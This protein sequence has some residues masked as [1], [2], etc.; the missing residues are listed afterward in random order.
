MDYYKNLNLESIDGE[1]WKDVEGYEGYYAISSLGRVRSY[2]RLV[3]CE[4]DQINKRRRER[5]LRQKV[6]RCGYLNI[7][8]FLNKIHKECPA[9]VLVAKAFIP[10]PKNKPQVNHKF[11]DKKDN[12]ASSLEWMTAKE[13]SNHAISIGIDSVVGEHN[14]RVKLTEEAVLEIRRLYP[15]GKRG[16]RHILAEKYNITAGIVTR[17]ARKVSWKH[18]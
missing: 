14:G 3:W 1:R 6:T 12:R 17:V 8:L 13:N 4:R 11:G 9:H 16:I 5:I 7:S 2:S 18:I 15:K 10:N